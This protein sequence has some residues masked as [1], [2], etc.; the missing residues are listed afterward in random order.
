MRQPSLGRAGMRPS[1]RGWDS[2]TRCS[3]W[4][5]GRAFEGRLT[6]Q[7]TFAPLNDRSQFVSSVVLC[8]VLTAVTGFRAVEV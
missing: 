8:S 5:A 4:N 7:G 6:E 3:V 1:I 2:A